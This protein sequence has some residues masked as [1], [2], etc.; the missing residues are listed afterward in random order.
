MS[1]ILKKTIILYFIL[2]AILLYFQPSLVID[3]YTKCPKP[4]GTGEGE[5]LIHLLLV[6]V[7]LAGFS[8]GVVRLV[9]G[10]TI[11]TK[12]PPE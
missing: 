1:S 11:I 12:L 8:V 7:L 10:T 3:P 2:V 9:S 5:T 6:F 4:F